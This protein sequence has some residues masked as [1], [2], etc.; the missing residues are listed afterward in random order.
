MPF[1]QPFCRIIT[2]YKANVLKSQSAGKKGGIHLF[3]SVTVHGPK[4]LKVKGK[5]SWRPLEQKTREKWA[6]IIGNPRFCANFAAFARERLLFFIP[7]R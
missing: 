3:F 5:L 4:T 6:Y 7:C 2:H 1:I